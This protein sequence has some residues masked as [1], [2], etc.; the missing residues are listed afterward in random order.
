[1][2]VKFIAFSTYINKNERT[3]I[4]SLKSQLKILEK[5]MEVIRKHKEQ[6]YLKMKA[7]TIRIIHLHLENTASAHL[8][9]LMDWAQDGLSASTAVSDPWCCCCR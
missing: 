5:T 1:M 8:Q 3:K 6:K 4:D 9:G 2:I 7:K